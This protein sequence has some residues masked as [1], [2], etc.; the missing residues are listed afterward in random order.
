[1]VAEVKMPAL[2]PTMTEGKIVAQDKKEGENLSVGDVILEVE[3]DKAVMEVEA[4]NKGTLGKILYQ[5][6]ETIAVGT[7]I[8]LILEKGETMEILKDYKIQDDEPQE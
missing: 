2:S 7:T 6:N 8:A 1:M 3:T 5:A 4:Q